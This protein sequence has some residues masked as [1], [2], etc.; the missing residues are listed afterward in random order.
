MPFKQEIIKKIHIT[1]VEYLA[2]ILEEG[3]R[4]GEIRADCNSQL[5]ALMLDACID[6]LLQSYLGT[7]F[8]TSSICSQDNL[9]EE[10]TKL[11]DILKHGIAS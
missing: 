11:I 8:E 10:V 6:R 1:S 4:K 9:E 5:I 3:K 7:H 2:P